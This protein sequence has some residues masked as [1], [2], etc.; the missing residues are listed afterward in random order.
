M[1]PD[2]WHERWKKNE[3]AFHEKHPNALLTCHFNKLSLSPGSRIFLPLC[4]KTLDISWLLSQGFRVA[5]AELN[6]GAI[7]QL[8]DALGITP[9]VRA[10]GRLERYHAENI[11]VFVGDIFD[12]SLAALGEVDAIYDRAALVALPEAMRRKYTTHLMEMTDK[13]PQLLV[14]FEYDQRQLEGPPFSVNDEEVQ[15]HYG[16]AYLTECVERRD[17]PGGLKKKCVASENAWILR[18]R[19]G[20]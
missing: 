1:E 14:C 11:D 13:A 5:G 9:K 19:A 16:A 17:V 10:E 20:R 7:G 2:F 8:F 18:T 6:G 15:R 12:L 4:G 3:T